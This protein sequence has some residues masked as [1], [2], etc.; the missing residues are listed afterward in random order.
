MAV[1]AIGTCLITGVGEEEVND[2]GDVAA[3]WT[4]SSRGFASQTRLMASS[5]NVS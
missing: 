1:V 5:T 3:S 2:P 4:I